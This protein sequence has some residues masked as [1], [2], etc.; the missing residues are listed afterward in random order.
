MSETVKLIIEI[1]KEDYEL[2]RTH[3]YTTKPLFDAVVNGIPL[4]DVKAEIEKH[5]EPVRIPYEKDYFSVLYALDKAI[6]ILDNIG[7]DHKRGVAGV[8]KE[9]RK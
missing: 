9:R 1:P 5:K 7:E 2:A 4:E 3:R 6:E 8:E